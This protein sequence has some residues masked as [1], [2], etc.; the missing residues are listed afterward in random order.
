MY[1][2]SGKFSS[3]DMGEKTEGECIKFKIIEQESSEIHF[4]VKIR[5]QE[6]QRIM[7]SETIK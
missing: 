3:E 5:P 1:D 2:Y 4:E 7:L 6:T